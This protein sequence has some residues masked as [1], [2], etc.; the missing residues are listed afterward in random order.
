MT[1]CTDNALVSNYV[2]GDERAF[3]EIVH[4]YHHSLWWTA[5]RYAPTDIDAQ[6]ILQEAYFKAALNLRHY[7][8]E[9]SLKTWLHQLV[10]NAGYDYRKHR[11]RNVEIALIDDASADLP[12]PSHDPLSALDLTLSLASA[13]SRLNEQQRAVLIMVDILGY[14]IYHTARE[15]KISDGTLKSRRSRAKYYLRRDHPEL[16]GM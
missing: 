16:V 7:R 9:A 4:R 1:L 13:L 12:H 14:T 10:R 3:A 15:L 11:Y 6:D 5:R 2:S 8:A